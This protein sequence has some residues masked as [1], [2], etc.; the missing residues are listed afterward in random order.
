MIATTQHFVASLVHSILCFQRFALLLCATA[1][2]VAQVSAAKSSFDRPGSQ[3]VT[4][5]AMAGTAVEASWPPAKGVTRWRVLLDDA[6]NFVTPIAA[7]TVSQSRAIFSVEDCA[8]VPGTVYYL[9]VEGIDNVATFSIPPARRWKIP[10]IDVA[11][12]TAA[13][14]HAGRDWISKYAGVEWVASEND[15]RLTPAWSDAS[16]PADK[17]YYVQYSALAALDLYQ[18]SRDV[19]IL[20]ELAKFYNVYLWRFST[21]GQAR[22]MDSQTTDQASLAGRGEDSART[23][24]TASLRGTKTSLGE[25]ELC[26]SQFLYPASRL[27]RT[28]SQL[29]RSE[30]TGGMN[31][32]VVKY[33]SL[34]LHDH[35]LRNL[36]AVKRWNVPLS[37]SSCSKVDLWEAAAKNTL[38]PPSK[39]MF[40]DTDLWYGATLAEILGAHANSPE[41]VPVAND[42]L[43]RLRRA[44]NANVAFL[45]SKRTLYSDT[46]DFSGRL[47]ESAS[48][49]NGDLDGHPDNAYSGYEGA[50]PPVPANQVAKAGISWDVSHIHRLPIYF[51]ALYDNRK[52]TGLSFPALADIQL[53]V[54]Q[55]LYRVLQGDMKLPLFN[56]FFDGGDGWFRVG[57]HPGFGGYPP[58]RYCMSGKLGNCLTPGSAQGWGM[59]SVFNPELS[60][61]ECSLI[62]LSTSMEKDKI[63]F[64]DNYFCAYGQPYS[65][66]NTSGDQQYPVLLLWIAAGSLNVLSE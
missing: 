34:V 2:L 36:Y 52:A 44:L 53:I 40:T 8:L 3:M 26:T 13:W 27:L 35:L 57:Y 31:E 19:A 50:A 45:Q 60:E 63:V 38:L 28:I 23:L 46:K 59:L 55:L 32:F 18:A 49:F 17:A 47:V 48:Y 9:R 4:V 51:R 43:A 22:R 6:P 42:D 58:A 20:D 1:A 12:V 30:W 15:W 66:F 62:S 7:I 41:D 64:R 5:H 24:F 14:K 11:Y 16:H 61:L 33:S 37:C 65:R 21:L 56:N 25:N 39:R 54:R 10:N 29:P